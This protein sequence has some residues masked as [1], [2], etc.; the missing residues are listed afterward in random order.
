MTD[1]KETLI[2]NHDRERYVPGNI[3]NSDIFNKIANNKKILFW[4]AIAHLAVLAIFLLLLTIELLS[5]RLKLGYSDN[6]KLFLFG[7]IGFAA[8]SN[9]FIFLLI[10]KIIKAK[11]QIRFLAVLLLIFSTIIASGSLLLWMQP[12]LMFYALV[13]VITWVIEIIVAY[14]LLLIVEKLPN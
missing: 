5:E 8:F 11:K 3:K 7:Y 2:Y 6:L 14:R 4:T 13:T 1:D 9:F 12:I 10:P